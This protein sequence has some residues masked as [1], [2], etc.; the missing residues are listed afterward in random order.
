[1]DEERKL[2]LP[3]LLSA[4]E[5]AS[6]QGELM[7]IEGDVQRTIL[8]RMG[9]PINVM[10][11]LQEETLGHILLDEGKLTADEYANLLDM[12]VQTKQRA[13]EILIAMGILGPQEVFS[14]LEFQTRR[15]LLN[16]F[17]MKDFGFSLE[18]KAIAPERL[19]CKVNPSEVIFSG[20]QE[21]YSVD[22]LLTEFPVDEETVFMARTIPVDQPIKM[23]PREN[24]IFR[25]IGTGNPMVK[26]MGLEK[27]LQML[28]A[29]LYSLH[30]LGLIEASG[31]GRPSTTDLEL[32]SLPTEL[33]EI[34]T[35]VPDQPAD[36]AID[37][38]VE[39]FATADDGFRPPTLVDALMSSDV[40]LALAKKALSM[41]QD[42][43]FKLLD[44]PRDANEH[45][46][47]TAYF[48][49]LRDFHLQDIDSHYSSEKER[50]MADRLLDKATI[51]YRELSDD[52]TRK[53]YLKTRQKSDVREVPKRIL[54]DV[55]AQ[56][57]QLAIAARRYLD[58]MELYDAA[59]GL[60]PEEPSYYFNFGLAG[61]L[62]A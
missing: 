53:T 52:E 2:Y 39:E 58:A 42:D 33:P 11:R 37:E 9:R 50:E 43:H 32:A 34:E 24:R 59:T 16:C 57:G 28:L 45:M 40:D 35:A 31:V 23:G 17:K 18:E 41:D 6:F 8:F 20:I 1:M 47:K 62:K 49:L 55:E 12:M 25:A 21:A 30:S 5:R 19:I 54:A 56:K 13:G 26:L 60:Y 51:A 7:L 46:L 10:S 15:K 3:Y 36:Q 61:Y 4:L 44:V 22:R 48:R 14:V 38:I 27:D 29:V